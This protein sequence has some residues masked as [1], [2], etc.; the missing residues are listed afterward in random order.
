MIE[1]VFMN[2]TELAQF[3]NKLAIKLDTTTNEEAELVGGM[4]DNAAGGGGG[5]ISIVPQYVDDVFFPLY[6]NT[7]EGISEITV[8]VCTVEGLTDL[9]MFASRTKG[10]VFSILNDNQW[11][12]PAGYRTVVSGDI[13]PSQVSVSAHYIEGGI[14]CLTFPT[15][16]LMIIPSTDVIKE[17][18]KTN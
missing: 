11:R 7:G 4:V 14:V 5:V 13:D 18:T 15:S 6:A 17:G 1:E 10:Y 8:T 3:K 2:N 12:I 16:G 9:S